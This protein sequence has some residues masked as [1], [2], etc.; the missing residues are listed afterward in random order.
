MSGR[1]SGLRT[2]D[3]ARESGYS[4]QQIR[5]LESEGVL[6]AAPRTGSGYRV[7]GEQHVHAAIAYRGFAAGIGP[8]DAKAVL[9]AARSGQGPELLA[10][11]DA[12]HARLHAERR[13]VALARRAAAVITAERVDDALPSDVMTISE[14][15]DALGVRTSTL[16]H[17]E[18]EGLV[19]PR[20]APGGGART[21]VPVDVRD[22]RIV[23]QLRM[24]GYGIA[25]LRT[26]MPELRRAKRWDEVRTML[27]DRDAAIDARSAA[28]IAGTAALHLSSGQA[29]FATARA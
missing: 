26:L 17:W 14:L 11:V 29:A 28:L 20:R 5:D 9:R 6:P 27:A 4:V 1:K 25:P 18:A 2:A 21:Y 19:S 15:A 24:A 3:V 16:R 7:Y 12:A 8:V 23:H 22:A 10:L 13:D